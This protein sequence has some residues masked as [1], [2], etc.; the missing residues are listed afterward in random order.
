MIN[1]GYLETSFDDI[2]LKDSSYEK[3]DHSAGHTNRAYIPS[4]ISS[5][6]PHSPNNN[7]TPGA[8][9]I[10]TIDRNGRAPSEPAR[11]RPLSADS[12]SKMCQSK[13]KCFAAT[14]AVVLGLLVIGVAVFLGIYLGKCTRLVKPINLLRI[15]YVY[16]MAKPLFS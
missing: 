2:D 10:Y 6:G 7:T 13:S 8:I 4:I 12:K 1:D 3:R 11:D 9:P 14:L 15:Y 16:A 5:S